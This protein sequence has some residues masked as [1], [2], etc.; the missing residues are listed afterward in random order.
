MSDL[1]GNE[2][3]ISAG[4]ERSASNSKQEIFSAINHIAN[5]EFMALAVTKELTH[6]G[7]RRRELFCR[8]RTDDPVLARTLGESWPGR[9]EPYPGY[10]SQAVSM[11]YA[12]WGRPF[13]SSL[14]SKAL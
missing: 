1:L 5:F 4:S 6:K 12:V 3:G 7:V 14:C 9:Q 13:C 2:S 10:S 8:L 11:P